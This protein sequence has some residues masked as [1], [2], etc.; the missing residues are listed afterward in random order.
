MRC[1]HSNK[2]LAGSSRVLRQPAGDIRARRG[3][4]RFG[5]GRCLS[6][7][8]VV[9][10]K[11]SGGHQAS[12]ALQ[13]RAAAETHIRLLRCHHIRIDRQAPVAHRRATG[14]EGGVEKGV[15]DRADGV[16]RRQPFDSL[17]LLS[18]CR[19]SVSSVARQ[20]HPTQRQSRTHY[21][22]VRPEPV[23]LSTW[24]AE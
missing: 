14:L 16:P 11:S 19:A 1:L 18:L 2:T 8:R 10:G 24:P 9:A 21:G 3:L 13:N 15:F 4:R 22:P 23:I 6:R 12:R 7:S 20:T 5:C 17:R